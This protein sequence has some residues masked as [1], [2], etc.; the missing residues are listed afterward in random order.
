MIYIGLTGW[1]D[2]PYLYTKDTKNKLKEYASHFPVVEVDSAFYAIQPERYYEK[3]A[4]D[5]PDLFSFIVKAYQGMTKH[6]KDMLPYH[7]MDDMFHHFKVSIQPLID[8]NKLK[9]VLFQFPPWYGCDKKNVDYL[10]YVKEQMGNI[11]M[12]LEFRNRT[13]FSA[14]FKEQTLHFMQS[15]GIIH[16]ICDEPD[17]GMTSVP[18]ILEPTHP[19]KT[20]IRFHGR[21]VHGWNN[22]GQSNWREVR[23]LYNYN[24][25][26]LLEWVNH[27][28]EL[29]RKSKDIYILFNNN[30]GGDAVLNAKRLIELLGIEYTFLAPKQL[31]LF[32]DL[33][34]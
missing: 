28:K 21:N 33:N 15:L 3:W 12:A 19:E 20:L 34:T 25:Q 27:L 11:P 30:S 22:Q 13:W 26:E 4:M 29:E 1:G 10:R 6:R 31:D 7:S 32:S 9:M 14:K 2:H 5:T 16:S 17:A 23:F 8:K 18:T 24:D